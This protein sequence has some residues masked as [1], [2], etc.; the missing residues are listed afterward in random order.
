MMQILSHRG[1]WKTKEEQNTAIAFRRSFENGFGVETD[2]RDCG[3][4]LVISHDMPDGSQIKLDEFFEIY[5]SYQSKTCL[6]LNIKSDGLQKKLFDAIN[7]FHIKNYFVFDMSVPDSIGYLNQGFSCFTRQ[8][9]YENLPLYEKS[10]GVWMD[11]FESDW[12]KKDDVMK[13]LNNQKKVCIVSSELHKRDHS[14]A[15]QKYIEYGFAD[16][17]HFMICTDYPDKFQLLLK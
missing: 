3:R 15:W 10:Q 9:E 17:Q 2:I 16:N 5:N 11:C 14:L 4:E 6:A 12:I 13:H 8:S 7:K 1:F